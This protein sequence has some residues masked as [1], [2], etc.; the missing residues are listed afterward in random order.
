MIRALTATAALLS[1]ASSAVAGGYVATIPSVAPPALSSGPSGGEW[2]IG[3]GLLAALMLL[4]RGGGSDGHITP[5]PPEHSGSCFLEGTRI[6]LDDGHWDYVENLR[7]NDMVWTSRGPQPVLHVTT[8]RPTSFLDRP[9]IV[10]GVALSPN[11]RVLIDGKVMTAL[12]ACHDQRGRI[13]GK[14][15]HHVLVPNHAWLKAKAV[16]GLATRC[17]SLHLTTDMPK[18]AQRFPHVL[19]AHEANPL[20]EMEDA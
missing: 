17:E 3:A 7:P 11:H 5:L 13:T 18:L 15:Y 10:R 14:A 16:S 2:L 4:L 12:D 19:A 9:C 8:W 20:I 1:S 6:H